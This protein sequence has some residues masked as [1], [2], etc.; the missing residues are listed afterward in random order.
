[1]PLPGRL[2][3]VTQAHLEQLIGEA[4]GLSVLDATRW[5]CWSSTSRAWNAMGISSL[6]RITRSGSQ[7]QSRQSALRRATSAAE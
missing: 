2:S 3:D 5:L 1:M 6:Y 7:T 4:E